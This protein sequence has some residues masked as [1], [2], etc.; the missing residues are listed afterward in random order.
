MPADLDAQ[1]KLLQSSDRHQ[2]WYKQVVGH[3]RNLNW[4]HW[5]WKNPIASRIGGC[6]LFVSLGAVN[7]SRKMSPVHL[8]LPGTFLPGAVV[9]Y[10]R[11]SPKDAALVPLFVICQK[12][13]SE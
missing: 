10:S 13:A 4:V 6:F 5:G 12:S 2:G 8:P 1:T 7:I 3:C 11:S 9:G